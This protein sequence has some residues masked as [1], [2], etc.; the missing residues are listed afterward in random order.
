M[1]KELKRAQVQRIIGLSNA[2]RTIDAFALPTLDP[3]LY[4]KYEE[5]K[6]H[7]LKI[8]NDGL[9][10]YEDIKPYQTLFITTRG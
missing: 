3:K 1:E 2:F 5:V 9:D 4:E 7:L 6:N 10:D 8:Y